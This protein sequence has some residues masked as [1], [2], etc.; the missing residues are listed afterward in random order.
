MKK[1]NLK[2]AS[3]VPALAARYVDAFKE[4]IVNYGDESIAEY[5]AI[6][7]EIKSINKDVL[8]SIAGDQHVASALVTMIVKNE[9]MFIN[10]KPSL[11]WENLNAIKAA[12]TGSEELPDVTD[13]WLNVVAYIT[14]VE[15]DSMVCNNKEIKNQEG[16]K[17]M[18]SGNDVALNS[19][20]EVVGCT[21]EG[22]KEQAAIDAGH[23]R[24][25]VTVVDLKDSGNESVDALVNTIKEC[26]EDFENLVQEMATE[27]VDKKNKEKSSTLTEDILTGVAIA[28][29]V[30]V[31]G[32]GLYYVGK[33]I[34]GSNESD[35]FL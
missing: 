26:G 8:M 20:S 15:K 19:G 35:M 6:N 29:G 17:N 2:V 33:A 5:T 3:Q 11:V 31:V 21:G 18:V 28:A 23:V 16:D 10:T 32:A 25:N 12:F 30:V 1:V 27:Y 22:L 34:F 7:K 14:V 24:T 13:K 4:V 9:G